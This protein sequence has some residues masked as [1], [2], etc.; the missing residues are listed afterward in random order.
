MVNFIR[1]MSIGEHLR[2]ADNDTPANVLRERAEFLLVLS[3][4]DL[5]SMEEWPLPRQKLSY[6]QNDGWNQVSNNYLFDLF[7]A[8]IRYIRYHFSD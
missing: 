3:T 2:R 7:C 5:S 6:K 1:V 8:D 4:L